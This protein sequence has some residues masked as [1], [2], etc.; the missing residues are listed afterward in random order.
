MINILHEA[1]D[2]PIVAEIVE[3][4][5]VNLDERLV[6]AILIHWRKLE[7]TFGPFKRTNGMTAK[8]YVLTVISELVPLVSDCMKAVLGLEITEKAFNYICDLLLE[9]PYSA[10]PTPYLRFEGNLECAIV[11]KTTRCEIPVFIIAGTSEEVDGWSQLVVQMKSCYEFAKN[12]CQKVV[13]QS[14][15][16]EVESET[17]AAIQRRCDDELPPDLELEDPVERNNR[18]RMI[19]K[20]CRKQVAIDRRLES[21]KRFTDLMNRSPLC[22]Y[23]LVSLAITWVFMKYDG[24]QFA[25]RETVVVRNVEDRE[26][27][28]QVMTIIHGILQQQKRMINTLIDDFC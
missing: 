12:L 21:E 23:G 26:N 15:F 1:H 5:Q 17:L 11:R 6:D 13:E 24:K 28:T 19:S 2:I 7:E 25:E 27:I 16:Q 20:Q 4:P 22:I 9:I 14:I 10:F 18:I 8:A 3:M